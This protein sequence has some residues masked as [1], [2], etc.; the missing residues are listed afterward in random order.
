MTGTPFDGIGE[1][2][3][4]SIIGWLCS[5]FTGKRVCEFCHKSFP[6]DEVSKDYLGRWKCKNH[7]GV[8]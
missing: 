2:I 4:K 8:G 6:K 1:D 5:V 3:K 7:E